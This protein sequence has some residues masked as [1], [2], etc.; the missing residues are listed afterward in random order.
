MLVQ[1][2]AI[3]IATLKFAEADLIVKCFTEACGLKT[4]ILKNILKSKKGKFR[5]SF[6]QPLTLLELTAHHK[7]KNNLEYL[8]EVHVLYHYKTLHSQIVKSSLVLFLSE[9]VKQSI[10]EEE[11]NTPLFDFLYKSLIWLDSHQEAANFHLL[12]LLKLTQ[13]LGFSPDASTIHKP[14][15]NPVEGIFQDEKSTLYCVSFGQNNQ[16]FK[17]LFGI[18]FDALKSLKLTKKERQDCLELLLLYYQLHIQGFKTPK[19]LSVLQQLF[20]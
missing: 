17:K 16:G 5:V 13:F 19:S 7:N 3:V 11:V 10:Q 6:F 18:N 9:I 20:N 8:N 12:F 4:Y 14:I 2:K 1:T 15:F